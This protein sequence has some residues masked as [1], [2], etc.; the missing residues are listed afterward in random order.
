MFTAWGVGGFAMSKASQIL[1][2]G[3]NT[4]TS[5]FIAAGVLLC[6]GAGLTYFIKDRKDIARHGLAQQAATRSSYKQSSF[7]S[8]AGKQDVSLDL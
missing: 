8:N 6:V 1:L 5:S 3:T 2:A 7:A 4:F